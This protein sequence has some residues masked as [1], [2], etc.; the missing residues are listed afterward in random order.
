[1]VAEGA[2]VD[3]E[4]VRRGLA[5]SREHAVALVASGR[6]RAD[7]RRVG[8]AAHRVGAASAL[9]V[10]ADPDDPG[11]ASRGAYKLA[12]ALDRFAPRGLAVRGRRCL[13]L[14]A[15]T[16]G[17]TDVL[18]RA[19]ARTVVCVDVG[20]GQL[21]RS[22]RDDAR[23]MVLE[24]R[25]VRSLSRQ[26]IGGT[27]DLTVADLSFISL[28]LVL[29]VI[30]AVT[31]SDGDLVLLVKPQFEVGRER[32]GGGGRGVV[33]S[34]A[35]RREAVRSVAGAARDLGWGVHGACPSALPGPSGNLEY[36][37]W[38]RR[39]RDALPPDAVDRSVEGDCGGEKVA[40]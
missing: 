2:R 10:D 1:M 14:G 21:V 12:G 11:Y 9:V 29:P 25:N 7:G 6:V 30:G 27:A 19:G 31:A 18:L 17:F 35:L 39:G 24:D 37:L 34:T 20:H 40:R 22:L 13:D 26:D 23:T 4:M 5:R 33:R 15:S 16:G 38:L 32:L 28:V 36:F 3:A 8:K